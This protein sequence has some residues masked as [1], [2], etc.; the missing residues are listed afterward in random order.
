MEQV[1]LRAPMHL[2]AKS[3]LIFTDCS[4]TLNTVKRT[5]VLTEAAT[6][7]PVLTSFVAK[8]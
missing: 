1:A 3:W 8:C 7:A 2:E 5:A 6:C 4:N